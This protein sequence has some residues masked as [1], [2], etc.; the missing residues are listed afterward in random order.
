MKN[1]WCQRLKCLLNWWWLW[2]QCKQPRR[3]SLIF[4]KEWQEEEGPWRWF[5]AIA[6][7]CPSGSSQRKLC[8]LHWII[9]SESCNEWQEGGGQEIKRNVGDLEYHKQEIGLGCP[10]LR[11]R[12]FLYLTAFEHDRDIL[13]FDIWLINNQARARSALARRACALRALGLLLADGTPTV[14]GGKTFWAVS[15]IFLRKQ[16]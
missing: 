11:P 5:L 12:L 10:I 6:C 1:D 2:H 7:C 14:G 15:Q 3:W 8:R 13:S 4:S 9:Y 16:L